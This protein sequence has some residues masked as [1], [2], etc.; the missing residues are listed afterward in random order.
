MLVVGIILVIVFGN[1][2]S[3]KDLFQKGLMEVEKTL[4][5]RFLP[6]TDTALNPTDF[7]GSSAQ[8]IASLMAINSTTFNGNPSQENLS[9]SYVSYLGKQ[10]NEASHMLMLCTPPHNAYSTDYSPDMQSAG[11]TLNN[12]T[13]SV[14][15]IIIV[16]AYWSKDEYIYESPFDNLGFYINFNHSPKH[17]YTDFYADLNHWSKHNNTDFNHWSKHNYTDFN[18]WSKHSHTDFNHS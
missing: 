14:N 7:V 9:A 10:P 11:K 13:D 2:K 5:I 1:K 16:A 15:Q 18:H 3:E 12:I 6:Y 17:S 4:Q 8:A